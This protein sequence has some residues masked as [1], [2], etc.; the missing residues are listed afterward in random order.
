[1]PFQF[2]GTSGAIPSPVQDNTALVFYSAEEAVLV[3]CSG[4]PY[5]KILKAGLDPMK[6]SS[7][8]VT[9]RH[10]DHVYGIPSLAHNMGLAGRKSTLHIY[11]LVETMP[12]LRGLIDLFPLEEKMPYRIALHEMPAKEG[13]E[14]LRAKGFLI[15]STPVK[16]GAP[17][18]GLRVEFNAPSERGAVVYSSDTSP[19]P[20]L[21]ALARG[22][23]ILIHEATFLHSDAPRAAEDGHTTGYQAG[24]VARQAGVKRLIPCH[25]SADL[26]D[27]LEELRQEALRAYPGPVELPEEFRE[28]RI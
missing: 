6:V 22:A 19:C 12:S 3:D 28:Y 20:S 25:F 1:M 16:H 4:S 7:L 27:R 11:A 2:F 14:V 13:H 24:E 9:H 26:Q 23:D 15:R 18:I 17:N 21:L 10:V 5:Q 8:I